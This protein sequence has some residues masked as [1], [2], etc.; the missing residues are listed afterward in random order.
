MFSIQKILKKEK[1]LKKKKNTK[2]IFKILDPKK[3]LKKCS[4]QSNFSKIF[5]KRNF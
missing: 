3:T 2:K 5:Q 4:M 1:S